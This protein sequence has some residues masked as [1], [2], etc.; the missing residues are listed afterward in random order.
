M[1]FLQVD[2]D[3]GLIRYTSYSPYTDDYVYFDEPA[4]QLEKYA[5]DPGGEQGQVPIPWPY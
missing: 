2:E 5:F 1:R 3:A 4:H